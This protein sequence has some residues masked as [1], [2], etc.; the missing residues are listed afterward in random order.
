MNSN[1]NWVLQVDP[2]VYFDQRGC[3]EEYSLVQHP[4]DVETLYPVI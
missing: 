4:S 2:V 1:E 3:V